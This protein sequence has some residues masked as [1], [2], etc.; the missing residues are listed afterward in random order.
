MVLHNNWQRVGYQSAVLL[1]LCGGGALP[2]LAQ[3]TFPPNPLEMTE[4]DPLLPR[5]VVDRPFSPQEL[6]VLNAAV[7]ELD[8]QAQARFNAGD[9]AEAFEIW[10]RVLRL[11]RV[12]GTEQEVESLSRV[13]AIAW[14]ENQTIE[15]RLITQRLQQIEQDVRAQPP[16]NY[17]LLLTIAQAYQSMRAIDPALVAYEEILIQ[18]RQE[19]NRNR[20]LQT[21][22]AMGQLHLAWFDYASA[23]TV[24]QQLLALVPN[25]RDRQ[26]QYLQQLAYSYQQGNQPEP[27]IAAQQQLATAY[28]QQEEYTEIPPLKLAIGDSYVALNR[29]DLAA[30][31]YQE[32]FAVSRST[33]QLAYASDALQK[34]ANLYVSIERPNDALVVYQLLLDVNQQSYNTYGLMET[35]DQIGQ[36]YRSQGNT[37]QAL[38]AFQRGLTLAQQLNY[39]TGYFTNQ[40]QQISQQ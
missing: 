16:L 40:I 26:V 20:Q 36:L 33:Q 2:A 24:Y 14:R 27:A 10:L 13:G 4:P 7:D 17:D 25:N 37:A 19:Q 21:L 9:T 6:S 34:L 29:P 5:L 31:N 35:Y 18:A 22:E 3:E 11:R 23:A 1:L 39:R 38:A 12:L 28:E 8:Q 32:A 30:T 15:V